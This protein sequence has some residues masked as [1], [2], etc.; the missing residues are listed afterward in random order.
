MT[1]VNAGQES[2]IRE[3]VKRFIMS[4]I[5]IEHLNDDDNLFE[6]GIVNSLFAV[7]LMTFIE[8]TF[9]I[10]VAMDDLDIENFKSLNAT[11]AFVAEEERRRGGDVRFSK[12]SLISVTLGRSGRRD[13]TSVDRPAKGQA[14]RVQAFRCIERRTRLPKHGIGNN[15]FPTTRFLN[16]PSPAIWAPACRRITADKDGTSSPSAC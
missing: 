15:K 6:T 12:R 13:A 2:G 3:T 4:S 1:A 7:Q 9:A 16:W 8:K 10:E 11:T 14:R 5:N